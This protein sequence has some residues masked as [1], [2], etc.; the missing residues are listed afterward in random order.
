V[1]IGSIAISHE[2]REY[3]I[4]AIFKERC[5]EYPKNLVGVDFAQWFMFRMKGASVIAPSS[6]IP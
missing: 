3:D 5:H 6:D 1:N 4:V 2:N